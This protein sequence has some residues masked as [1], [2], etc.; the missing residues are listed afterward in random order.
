MIE[1]LIKDLRDLAQKSTRLARENQQSSFS[2]ALEALGINL[3][4]KALELEQRFARS[5]APRT[6]TELRSRVLEIYEAFSAGKLDLLADVFDEHVDFL[7]NA[8]I[9]LFPYLGHRVGKAD[10]VKTLWAVHN[11]FKPLSFKPI[12]IITED[13]AAGVLVSIHATQ[14]RTGR[15]IH[16]FA[17]HF[18][19]F[20][21]D[22]IVEYRA[23]M[24][25][26]EAVQQVLGRELHL[27]ENSGSSQ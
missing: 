19:R 14:R 11:E 21:G 10:V 15:V 25:S 17:A 2:H 4:E 23:V 12:R 26:L 5:W 13:D 22:R 24:D 6:Q 20:R 16:F 8:P 7:S 9:E 1:G 3:M 27:K 18:L